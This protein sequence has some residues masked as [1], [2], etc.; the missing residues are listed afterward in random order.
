[1]EDQQLSLIVRFFSFS[2][3]FFFLLHSFDCLLHISAF[4]DQIF[5][6]KPIKCIGKLFSF[7]LCEELKI[8]LN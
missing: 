1:M 4:S 3:I 8:M 6:I 2:F 7:I 5:N